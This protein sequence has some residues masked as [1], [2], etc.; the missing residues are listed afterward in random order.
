MYLETTY[1]VVKVIDIWHYSP[2]MVINSRQLFNTGHT[3]Q[4]VVYVRPDIAESTENQL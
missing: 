2:P 4:L 1:N 3:G